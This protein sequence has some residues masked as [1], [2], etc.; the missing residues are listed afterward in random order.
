M[1]TFLQFLK[2]VKPGKFDSVNVYTFTIFE[3]MQN[4]KHLDF[5]TFW[6]SVK[7]GKFAFLHF[8]SF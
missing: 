1:F 6:K 2:S 3:K 5:Y 8:Y 7:P 4:L